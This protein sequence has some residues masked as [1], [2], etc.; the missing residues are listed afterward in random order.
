MSKQSEDIVSQWEEQKMM[1]SHGKEIEKLLA[2][3]GKK[4]G[5]AKVV[6]AK[7]AKK[8]KKK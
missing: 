5:Q 7:P 1:E 2:K 4:I 6:N 8:K 3:V